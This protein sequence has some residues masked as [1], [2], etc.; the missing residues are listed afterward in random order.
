MP[1]EYAWNS[2]KKSQSQKV[3]QLFRSINQI[4]DT[5]PGGLKNET[6]KLDQLSRLKNTHTSNDQ[7]SAGAPNARDNSLSNVGNYMTHSVHTH[8]SRNIAN[9]YGTNAPQSMTNTTGSLHNTSS[10]ESANLNSSAE[11]NPPPATTAANLS[12]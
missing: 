1:G 3:N 7:S 12:N 8:K 4:Q 11:Q 9:P 5:T 2:E 10:F 6:M